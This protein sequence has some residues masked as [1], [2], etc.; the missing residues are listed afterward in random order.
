MIVREY[1]WH[2]AWGIYS[3]GDNYF[4]RTSEVG[5]LVYGESCVDFDSEEELKEYMDGEWNKNQV[6]YVWNE[7]GLVG[8]LHFQQDRKSQ[9]IVDLW[10]ITVRGQVPEFFASGGCAGGTIGFVARGE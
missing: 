8:G 9:L 5:R 10:K 4:D 3:A 6:Q 7:D 1:I 2:G